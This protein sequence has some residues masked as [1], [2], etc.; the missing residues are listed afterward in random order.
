MK[1]TDI[2]RA[3]LRAGGLV[4]D[5]EG[6]I[7]SDDGSKLSPFL[8][9]GKR[10]VLPT[11]EFQRQSDKSGIV[12]F[13]PLC[14]NT[15]RGESE[16]LEA[17][18]AAINARTQYVFA[19]VAYQLLMINTSVET[20]KN[21][22]PEQHEFLSKVKNAD[23]T[24]VEVLEKIMKAMPVGQVAKCFVSI[25]LK[26][27]GQIN[28][29]KHARVGVV[30][31]PLYKE[32]IS[33]ESIASKEVYGVKI[34]KKADRAALVSLLEYMMPAIETPHSYDRGSNDQTAP[35]LDALMKA[36]MAIAGPLNDVIEL[37]KEHL[38]DP[39]ALMFDA[40]WVEAFKDLGV[41]EA[42]IRKTPMQAGN[43]GATNKAMPASA[44]PVPV[45]APVYQAPVPVQPVYQAQQPAFMQAQQYPQHQPMYQPPPPPPQPVQTGRGVDWSSLVHSS[46]ALAAT[47]NMGQ[48]HYHPQQGF[49]PARAGYGVQAQPQQMYQQQQPMY[50]QQQPAFQQQGRRNY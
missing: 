46:P 24:T 41:L 17:F 2:Y 15:L 19:W 16:V 13:H 48:N 38:D 43:E 27:S 32:L 34:P 25:Y 4:A 30:S 9:K 49:S 28:G 29:V 40:S 12:L 7:S 50:Q 1:L 37:F 33:P 22:N 11:D 8:V 45:P 21:L 10:L 42:E 31:F 47:V 18:R 26:R 6:F 5:A 14:E 3:I 23:G 35:N 39:E 44:T 20:H 36:F